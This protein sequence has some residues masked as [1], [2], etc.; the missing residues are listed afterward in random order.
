MPFGDQVDI[1]SG[2]SSSSNTD[3]CKMESKWLKNSVTIDQPVSEFDSEGMCHNSHNCLVILSIYSLNTCLLIWK[4][5]FLLFCCQMKRK[6][7]SSLH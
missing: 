6:T 3:D 4:Q 5:T 7:R 1:S 2:D